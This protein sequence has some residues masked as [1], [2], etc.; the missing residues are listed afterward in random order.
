M[1]WVNHPVMRASTLDIRDRLLSRLQQS[2][3]CR[4][5]ERNVLTGLGVLEHEQIT[6]ALSRPPVSSVGP[7]LHRWWLDFLDRAPSRLTE[8][9]INWRN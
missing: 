7:C 2:L 5:L 6:P 8:D 4:K 1:S 3:Q 9:R